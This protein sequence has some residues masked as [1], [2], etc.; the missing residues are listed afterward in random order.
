MLGYADL[1]TALDLITTNGAKTLN[2]SHQYGIEVGK[3]ANFIIYKV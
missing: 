3:P 2:I 1:K